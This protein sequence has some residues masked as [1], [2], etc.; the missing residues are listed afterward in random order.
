MI[1]EQLGPLRRVPLGEGEPLRVRAVGHE[2]RVAPLDLGAEHVRAEDDPVVH[3]DRDVPIDPHA[4]SDLAA[5]H[6]HSLVSK[7][8]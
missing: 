5:L 7:W 6:R 8:K 2:H 3:L 1:C 4:I